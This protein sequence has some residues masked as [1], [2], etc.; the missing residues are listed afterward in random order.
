MRPALLLIAL[1][2][3]ATASASGPAP[4]AD[5]EEAFLMDMVH[6]HQ[7]AIDMARMVEGR[8]AH[9]D[10]L[11]PFAQV[12][13]EKQ[14]EE[15][16]QMKGWHAAWYG[17]HASMAMPEND[18]MDAE[19]QRMMAELEGK[20]GHAFD[21]A[22]LEMMTM[23]HGSAIEMAEG[24]RAQ[25]VHEETRALADGIIAD[26]EAEIQKMRAWRAAWANETPVGANDTGA[27][28][29]MTN[30]TEES[31]GQE[32]PALGIVAVLALAGFAALALRRRN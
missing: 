21:L 5:A 32:V 3:V 1:L 12:I 11:E 9:P 6:H 29:D 20:E 10:E 13:I 31:T 15:I 18:S 30:G 4:A 28:A 2:A 7:G 16:G 27:D 25:D 26:Q 24:I 22:F 14:Q 8:T 19:M 17:E 23:H